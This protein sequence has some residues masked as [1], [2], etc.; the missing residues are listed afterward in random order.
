MKYRPISFTAALVPPVLDET[1]TQT[2]RVA[3]IP[4]GWSIPP[5][6]IDETTGCLNR[7]GSHTDER[8]ACPYGKVGDRLW[9]REPYWQQGFWRP[10]IGRQTKGGR[11]K[12]EFCPIGEPSFRKRS[13][14][15]KGRHHKDSGAV[16]WHQR[17][18]RFMPRQYSRITL[19]IVS[20]RVERLHDISEADC[21]AEGIGEQ[22]LPLQSF[23]NLCIQFPNTDLQTLAA[24][25]KR[26]FHFSDDPKS[27]DYGKV[28]STTGRGCYAYLWESINGPGS[29]AKNPFVWVI[30]FRRVK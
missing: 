4:I 19:E 2:R 21:W 27:C 29:W 22:C 7:F 6:R 1:K 8:I 9:V 13:D 16:A 24:G 10:V 3:N 20:V 5:A 23:A 28:I 25:D 26:L 17:L 14:A 30:Q 15:R 18:A 12:W 11:Q